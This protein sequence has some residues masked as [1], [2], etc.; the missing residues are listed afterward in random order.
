MRCSF[1]SLVSLF[2]IDFNITI[3]FIVSAQ[4]AQ[5]SSELY[6]VS[7]SNKAATHITA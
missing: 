4:G 3:D 1:W 7:E 5:K 2:T 6:A